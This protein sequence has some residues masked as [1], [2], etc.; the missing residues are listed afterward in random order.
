MGKDFL[1]GAP[2]NP[3][4]VPCN[5]ITSES[6]RKLLD[7]LDAGANRCRECSGTSRKGAEYGACVCGDPCIH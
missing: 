4:P 2:P 1:F 7:S 3:L 5:E 6:Q